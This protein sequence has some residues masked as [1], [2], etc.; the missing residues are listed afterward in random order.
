MVF[1][2]VIDMT[3]LF[4]LVADRNTTFNKYLPFIIDDSGKT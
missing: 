2:F 4:V 1:K 3:L